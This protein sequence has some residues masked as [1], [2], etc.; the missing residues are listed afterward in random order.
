MFSA[1]YTIFQPNFGILLLLK[2]SF[3]GIWFFFVWICLDQKLVYTGKENCL[4]TRMI[5]KWR[6]VSGLNCLSTLL[7]P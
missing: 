1:H 7:N 4:L 3:L 6:V 5:A 2:G